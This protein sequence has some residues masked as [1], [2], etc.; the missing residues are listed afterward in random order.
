MPHPQGTQ[1]WL[2]RVAYEE[3]DGSPIRVQCSMNGTVVA[4]RKQSDGWHCWLIDTRTG[5]V[6]TAT[7]PTN[8]RA[9][10]DL[11]NA[12]RRGTVAA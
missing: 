9:A 6:Y 1:G 3:H 11:A 12:E 2:P 8:Q 10:F 4:S 5:E 7:H